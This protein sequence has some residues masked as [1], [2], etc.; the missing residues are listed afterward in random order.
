MTA[1]D[2]AVFVD[3]LLLLAVFAVAGYDFLDNLVVRIALAVLL[4]STAAAGWG[5]WLAPNASRRL[6]HPRRLVVKLALVAVAA[7][8]LAA[9]GHPWL[10]SAFLVV[11]VV[12]LTAGELLARGK[13]VVA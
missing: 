1:L 9:T 3:E 12:L 6:E 8:L 7:S 13:G 4:P 5:R 10:A 11:S 2:A